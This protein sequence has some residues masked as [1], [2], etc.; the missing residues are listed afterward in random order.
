MANPLYM[1][2]IEV[3]GHFHGGPSVKPW[4]AR[5][6]GPD[7]KF[8]LAR[9]FVKAMYDWREA[10]RAW[11]GN[12]YGTV[13]TFPLRQGFLYEVSRTYGSSSKRH[14]MRTFHR[15]D[16]GQMVAVSVE[17]V[18]SHAAKGCGGVALRVREIPERTLVT[19]LDGED[20]VPFVVRDS[21]RVYWLRE[22]RTYD[23]RDVSPR[24]GDRNRML[25]VENGEC[26][27]VKIT[28]WPGSN[29]NQ[30]Q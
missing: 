1:L 8:G 11:S 2:R 21:K 26:R 17:D 12:L 3:D 16:G 20:P 19:D 4:V 13:A 30:D 28:Q 27:E 15:V 24:G 7:L 25:T 18:L 5:I 22:G 9:S 29:I 6:D 23:V 14:V 10:R